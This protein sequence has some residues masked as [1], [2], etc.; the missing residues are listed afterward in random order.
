MKHHLN[1][2]DNIAVTVYIF[3]LLTSTKG[4][5]VGCECLR[6]LRRHLLKSKWKFRSTT[7]KMV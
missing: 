5:V 3:T 2:Y 6:S 1:L 7:D 4:G